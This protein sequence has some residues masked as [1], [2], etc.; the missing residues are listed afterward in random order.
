MQAMTRIGAKPPTPAEGRTEP[1]RYATEAA[2]WQAVCERDRAAEG[3]FYFAVV[4]TGV[5]CRPNCA[6]RQPRRENVR[7]FETIA[8]AEAAGFRACKRCRPTG[9]SVERAQAD[10]VSQACHLIDEAETPPV[11]ADLARAVGMSPFHFHRVFKA[12]LGVTPKDYAAARRLERLKRELDDGT[13]V[14]QAIYGA[15]FGSSSRLYETTHATLGMTP[16]A[17]QK[18]AK[19]KR[20]AWTVTATTLGPLLLAATAD[21]VCMIEFGED[22]AT[23][24]A[25]LAARFPE[26]LRTRDDSTLG[27]HVAA[28]T[29]YI[30]T[31]SKGL[32][33]PLD[34]QGTAF[35]RR[36]WRALQAIPPGHT[37]T[38]GEVAAAL[39]QPT[40]ARAVARACATNELA[41]AIPCHRVVGSDGRLAGYRWGVERKLALLAAEKQAG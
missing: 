2:R 28:L 29:A 37:A 33:L 20:I 23:L 8:A 15:G 38:Y 19:G 41:L 14:S 40:A 27:R 31:P 5:F 13:P 34:I 25:E 35:Q 6:A 24:E 17:F 32:S 4:T 18:G 16:A 9:I 26:A 21:G 10:A 30:A 36:V 3:K 12:A 7:F 39:G 1:G 11:L 22:E